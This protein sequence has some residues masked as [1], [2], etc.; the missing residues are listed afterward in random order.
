MSEQ[1]RTRRSVG[2]KALEMVMRDALDGMEELALLKAFHPG[3]E[4]VEIIA[5][6]PPSRPEPATRRTPAVTQVA[7]APRARQRDAS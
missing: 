3:A 4:V 6:E 7:P 5:I 2:P 1:E